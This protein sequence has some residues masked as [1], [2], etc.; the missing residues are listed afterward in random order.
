LDP[1]AGSFEEGGG[2]L[3]LLVR[4]SAA[5]GEALA[6]LRG[7]VLL[8]V[9]YGGPPAEPRGADHPVLEVPNAVLGASAWTEAWVSPRSAG[10]F[11]RG[12]LA[13][14]EDGGALFG[15]AAI[16]AAEDIEQAALAVYRD[17]LALLEDRGYPWLQRSWNYVPGIN[18]PE[19]GSERYKRFNAGRALGFEERYGA[20]ARERFSAASAVGT[21]G[22]TLLVAFAAGREPGTQVENPRQVSAYRYP[23]AYGQKSPSFS[24]GTVT[25][26]DW[27]R[28]FF[29]SGTASVVGHATTHVGEPLGQLEETLSNIGALLDG[30]SAVAGARRG[31]SLRFDLLKIYVRRPEHFPA[32]RD[33]LAPRLDPATVAVYLQADICRADLLLEIEGVAFRET[34]GGR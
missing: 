28:A 33:A 1:E 7:R 2:G 27:G 9:R 14:A 18:D 25:P 21:T 22:E 6:G 30:P 31:G 32:I 4:P 17:M 8:E 19:G 10:C 26:P 34:R 5:M 13:W 11:R 23:S 20:A 24:R 16:P 29:L 3:T 15:C 12:A